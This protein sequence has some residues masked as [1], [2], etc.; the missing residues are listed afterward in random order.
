MENL[1]YGSFCEILL[2]NV[3]HYYFLLISGSSWSVLLCLYHWKIILLHIPFDLE[4]NHRDILPKVL[5]ESSLWQWM[6]L[7]KTGYIHHWNW[8]LKIA[9]E[10]YVVYVAV[11]KRKDLYLYIDTKRRTG[12]VVKSTKDSTH[13]CRM[14]SC[15]FV[16]KC[17]YTYISLFLHRKFWK[18][19]QEQY[20]S[21]YWH[22]YLMIIS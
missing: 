12:Y 14:I 4:T 13:V 9:L 6:K 19:T 10:T 22:Y 1:S 17:S 20:C 3:T 8:F 11:K 18:D 15:G 7:S 2:K 16:L 21:Y 5:L